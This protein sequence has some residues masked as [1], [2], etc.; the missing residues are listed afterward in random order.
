MT[1][2]TQSAAEPIEFWFDFSSGYG[3]FA[4]L[5]IEAVAARHGRA[6][7]WRPFLLGTAFKI[8]GATGLSR[9]PLKAE[10]ADLDWH[11]IARLKNVTFTLPPYH[12]ATALP[13]TRA[14]YVIE[15][16]SVAD[17]VR[18]AKLAYAAYFS[19]R[20]NTGD[21]GEVVKFA[22]DNGFD[23][24]DVA[25]GISDEGIKQ[26]VRELGENATQRG[27]FGSPWMFVGNEPFWGWDRLDM[28]DQWLA[29]GGW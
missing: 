20:L 14:F 22:V 25:T 26:R 24:E 2:A 5:D 13:A 27:V 21:G 28:L 8:T 11:R 6:V 12:P 19:G 15:R 16:K 7:I 3:Y 18:F 17:A 10:Y 4:S 1:T 23:G 9:T 29:T